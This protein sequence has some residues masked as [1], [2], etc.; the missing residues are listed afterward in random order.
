MLA[1]IVTAVVASLGAALGVAAVGDNPGTPFVGGLVLALY[2]MAMGAVGLAVGGLFRA[3]W[4]TVVTTE[5]VA[6]GLM[7]E[8]LVPALDLPR[9][10]LDLNLNS[11]YGEPMVGNWDWV[12]VVVSIGLAVGGLL[13]GAWG[14]SRRDLKG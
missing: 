10:V 11:H 12:G 3:G 14:F 7:I 6:S 13:I 5:I 9:W 1:L 8:I 2:A 4:A